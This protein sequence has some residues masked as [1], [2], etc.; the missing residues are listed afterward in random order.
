VDFS[1]IRD[2][3]TMGENLLFEWDEEKGARNLLV[4]GLDFAA[5]T[6]LFD[7]PVLER[8]DTRRDYGE[9]RIVALGMIENECF[10]VVYTPRGSRRRI[11]SVRRANRKERNEYRSTYS[12]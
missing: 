11:I 4:H 5:A 9:Q 1:A 3:R 2:S 6:A 12:S 10:V 8:E 7:N